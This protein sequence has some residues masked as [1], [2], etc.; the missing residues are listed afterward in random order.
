[1]N[2]F[3][4]PFFFRQFL[5]FFGSRRLF[6][7]VPLQSA[8]GC[9]RSCAVP[10]PAFRPTVSSAHFHTHCMHC[11][12]KWGEKKR[13]DESRSKNDNIRGEI[14]KYLTFEG[15][16][17]FLSALFSP[18]HLE[19]IPLFSSISLCCFHRSRDGA[20]YTCI[21]STVSIFSGRIS[22]AWFY[23]LWLCRSYGRLLFHLLC[24]SVHNILLFLRIFRYRIM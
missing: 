2:F 5:A 23:T 24:A 4:E 6:S 7:S 22:F 20:A 8:S 21:A 13:K 1:M 16:H 18:L 12:W 3:L 15:L 17:C 10:A 9:R 11:R 19:L 14:T